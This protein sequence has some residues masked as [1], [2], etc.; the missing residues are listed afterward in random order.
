M[1]LEIASSAEFP[2]K[3]FPS[4]LVSAPRVDLPLPHCFSHISSSRYPSP[5]P[6]SPC[7]KACPRLLHLLRPT[8]SLSLL[9]LGPHLTFVFYRSSS[10]S[11]AGLLNSKCIVS[12]VFPEEPSHT[13][14]L[15]NS[16]LQRFL[17]FLT[18]S[19]RSHPNG[20]EVPKWLLA[21]RTLFWC[22]SPS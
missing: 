13:L 14:P 12:L 5:L 6:E 4:A 11:D 17:R 16:P 10:L 22:S 9:S 8:P 1:V 15:S 3:L 2:R 18:V 7:G 19:H 20:G 21:E